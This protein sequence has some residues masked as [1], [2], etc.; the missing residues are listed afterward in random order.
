M[1]YTMCPCIILIIC[2]VTSKEWSRK[3]VKNNTYIIIESIEQ[4][5]FLN[6]S[7]DFFIS[8]NNTSSYTKWD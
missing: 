5:K 2:I 8:L 7:I 4:L 1:Q 3:L 6:S